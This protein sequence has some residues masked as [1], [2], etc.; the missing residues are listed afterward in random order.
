MISYANDYFIIFMNIDETLELREKTGKLRVFTYK[1]TH[2]SAADS[3]KVTSA[4]AHGIM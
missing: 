4:R 2:I 3:L 1:I